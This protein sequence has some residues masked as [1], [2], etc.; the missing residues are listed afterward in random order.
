MKRSMKKIRN[1]VLVVA[2]VILTSVV[3]FR[4]GQSNS[5]QTAGGELDLSMM[6][7]V[8]SR[9]EKVFL[10]KDTMDEKGMTYGA[11][12][13][14]VS[15][16]GDPYTVYLPPKD[17][18]SSNEDLAGEFGGVGISLGYKDKTL[19]V[20]TPLPKTPAEVAGIKAGDLIVRIK[21]SGKNIDRDTVG[22]ALDEAVEIIRGKVGT[23]V[24][25]TLLREGKDGSFEVV[26]KRDNIVVPSVEMEWKEK[27]GKKFAWLKV[28]K[29]TERLSVEWNEAVE[30]IVKE[31]GTDYGGVVLDLRNN[32]GGY[33]QSSVMVASDFLSEGVVVKQESGDGKV[34]IYNVEKRKQRLLN[35]KMVILMNGGS[36]S[37]SEILAGALSEHGRGK[38]VGETTF[39]K[40]TVQQ[41][42]NFDDGSG[43]HVTV[44][45]WLLP[46]GKNIHKEGVSPD[47][48]ISDDSETEEDEQ[49]ERAMQVL[50]E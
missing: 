18:K 3:S 23:E 10:D 31:K 39:G 44:A 46:S 47:V 11:I 14:M 25:L 6:W 29:F 33:L 48:E 45:K 34:E 50:L 36:A 2:L 49:L 8:K 1:V 9:L 13:G 15:A 41:P 43:L 26:L 4:L 38:M 5:R 21:D 27:D 42:E 22:I 35:D 32:P 12:S 24:I 17:N 40:G 7:T 28:Y 37:A 19:A 20:M 16:L 30:K